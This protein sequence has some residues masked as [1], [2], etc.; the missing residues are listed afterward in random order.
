[1]KLANGELALRHY[2]ICSNP[3]RGDIYE[4]AVLNEPNGTDGSTAVF[5]QY[6]LGLV[7][8]CQLPEN[9]F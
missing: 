6:Q 1:M 5:Q 2:S 7:L 9:Y 4:I 3:L 8:G